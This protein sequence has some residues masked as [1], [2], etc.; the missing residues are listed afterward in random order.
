MYKRMLLTLLSLLLLTVGVAGCGDSTPSLIGTWQATSGGA[1][2]LGQAL[3]CDTIAAYG[4]VIDFIDHSNVSLA[5][6]NAATYSMIDS[7]HLKL[8]TSFASVIFDMTLDNDKLVLTAN[9]RSTTFARASGNTLPLAT[10]PSPV[11]GTWRLAS[12]DGTLSIDGNTMQVGD[13]VRFDGN[14]M[15]GTAT[16][17]AAVESYTVKG[18]DQITIGQGLFSATYTI[19]SKTSNN[20]VLNQPDVLFGGNYAYSFV[21]ANQK[22]S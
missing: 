18:P 5:N 6:N 8:T 12:S 9:G 13:I 21:A 3:S 15:G 10:M 7:S 16:D 2:T 19:V 20:L 4:Q 17:G 1:E 22:G 14:A 11:G